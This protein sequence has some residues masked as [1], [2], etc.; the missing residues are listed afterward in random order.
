M[1]FIADDYPRERFADPLYQ[2]LSNHA[3]FGFIAHYDIHGFYDEQLS[4]PERRT[5]FLS[6]L[7]D[8]CERDAGTVRPDLWTDVKA[9]RSAG[10][11]LCHRRVPSCQYTSRS[12][13]QEGSTME[14]PEHPEH[15]NPPGPPVPPVP[16]PGRPVG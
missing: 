16:P 15:P 1:R 2:A 5:R 11:P 12:L 10:L 8:A 14:H 7:I 4:T 6:V 3:S 9:L 13:K